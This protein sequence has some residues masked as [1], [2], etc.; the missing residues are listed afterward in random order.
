MKTVN[1][2]C[3]LPFKPQK[4]TKDVD[5]AMAGV[6]SELDDIFAVK[7]EQRMVL[8]A[9]VSLFPAG[10]GKS[11]NSRVHC[12]SSQ[13]GD[14]PLALCLTLL[15]RAAANRLNWHSINPIGPLKM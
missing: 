3:K 10:F 13:G 2:C 6:L 9:F 8:K 7:K 14:E 5:A 15:P 11:F 12:G 1:D 4:K